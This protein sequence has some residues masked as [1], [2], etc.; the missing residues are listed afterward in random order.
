MGRSAGTA[1]RKDTRGDNRSRGGKK[2]TNFPGAQVRS[3][4]LLTVIHNPRQADFKGNLYTDETQIKTRNDLSS[5]ICEDLCAS[6]A[7]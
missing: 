6:V 2:R 4:E 3:P 5:V 7:Y 1:G